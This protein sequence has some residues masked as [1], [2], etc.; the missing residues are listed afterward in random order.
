MVGGY[1]YEGI[2]T[3]FSRS[4]MEYEIH[5]STCSEMGRIEWY[6]GPIFV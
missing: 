4:S 3:C 5:Q 1:K 6:T 2:Y